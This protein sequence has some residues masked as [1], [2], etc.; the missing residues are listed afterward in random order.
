MLLELETEE[1][2]SLLEE[3]AAKKEAALLSIKEHEQ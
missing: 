1:T 2:L 3:V